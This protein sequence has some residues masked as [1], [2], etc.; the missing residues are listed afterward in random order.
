[1]KFTDKPIGKREEDRLH[2]QTF[3]NQ[4]S[5][6]ILG[7][8]SEDPLVIGL[9][10][11]WGDG[12]TSV[13]NMLLEE[14]RATC[15]V[16]VF[17]PWHFNNQEELL[18]KFLEE[19]FLAASKQLP[20]LSA[21]SLRRKARNLATRLS[22][23]P[24]SASYSGVSLKLSDIK[25]SPS[26]PTSLR[27]E[28]QQL[29]RARSRK[30]RR[31]ILVVVD[32]LDR[33][34]PNEI[35]LILKLVTLCTDLSDF[36]FLLSFDFA[37]VA[38]S[39]QSTMYASGEATS[40][41]E[42]LRKIIQADMQLP[43]IDPDDI[44]AFVNEAF[45]TIQEAHGFEWP[46]DFTERFPPFYQKHIRGRVVRNLRD[47]KKLANAAAFTFPMIRGELNYTDWLGTEILRV[48]FPEAY[49]I[50]SRSLDTLAPPY[51]DISAMMHPPERER[52]KSRYQALSDQIP[53][54]SKPAALA[55]LAFL[56]PSF[57]A[58]QGNP[59]NP[60]IM[61]PDIHTEWS[62]QQRIASHDY[63]HRYFLFGPPAAK[64]SDVAVSLLIDRFNASPAA[65]LEDLVHHSLR[66]LRANHHLREFLD[67]LILRADLIDPA[68][69]S[70]LA[71][72]LASAPQAYGTETS[73]VMDSEEDRAQALIFALAS[74]EEATGNPTEVL[75]T[76]VL[77][78]YAPSFAVDIVLFS[79]PARNKI[80]R[81]F[82]RIDLDSVK[83]ALSEALNSQFEGSAKN[84]FDESVQSPHYILYQWAGPLLNQRQQVQQYLESLF[85]AG[86]ANL[87]RFLAGFTKG[88]PL[89]ETSEPKSFDAEKL[90][91]AFDF[92]WVAMH[93]RKL[94]TLQGLSPREQ[95]AL[96]KFAELLTPDAA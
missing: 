76:A 88:D 67:R 52:W 1:M 56:F 58:W 91:E 38:Q 33:L 78:A 44:D 94:G 49:E 27:S 39:L 37:Y 47:A 63:A 84:I 24:L 10:G 42:Y 54:A 73:F 29:L 82:S 80:L 15:T 36:I 96:A 66:D 83:S 9:Y 41:A 86:P 71:G 55:I 89:A 34:P 45:S 12:K 31:K 18:R 65:Q 21:V 90:R 68:I 16:L 92:D 46:P 70:N 14:T 6:A 4:L 25:P 20:F 11:S 81:D 57:E 79:T 77:R 7:W 85:R 30:R 75:R 13:I 59:A 69:R 3:V 64:L 87:V 43:A 61:G 53:S 40:G 51:H 26:T 22:S 72:A 2:R 35:A 28:I 19:I 93:V 60:S 48:F 17:D 62:K 5:R 95:F 50:T 23:I 74:Q 8:A 32:N